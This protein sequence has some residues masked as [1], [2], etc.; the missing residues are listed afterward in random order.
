MKIKNENYFMQ[1]IEIKITYATINSIIIITVPLIIFFFIIIHEVIIYCHI[2]NK[3]SNPQTINL[4]T[5]TYYELTFVAE[6]PHGG[7]RLGTLL[8]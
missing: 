5:L 8:D 3:N 4:R 7:P 6:Q 1:V 2:N